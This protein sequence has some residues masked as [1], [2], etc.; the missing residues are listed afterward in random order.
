M[1]KVNLVLMACH[2]D[3]QLSQVVTVLGKR[4]LTPE[5]QTSVPGLLCEG[6]GLV[7]GSVSGLPESKA[8]SAGT[9]GSRCWLY[10]SL[11]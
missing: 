1:E 9:G 3:S 5:S 4:W 11:W 2:G 10:C 7:Y 6:Q 8:E